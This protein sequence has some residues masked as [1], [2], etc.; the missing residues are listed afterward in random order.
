MFFV[1][2]KE[3]A[4]EKLGG[5]KAV[6]DEYKK[7]DN[8]ILK[9][10]KYLKMLAVESVKS[11]L[12]Q[13]TM[14]NIGEGNHHLQ[15]DSNNAVTVVKYFPREAGLFLGAT[16][17]NAGINTDFFNPF[18]SICYL[19]FAVLFVVL[20]VRKT[21]LKQ[22]DSIYLLSIMIVFGICFNNIMNASLAN[23][24]N[25]FGVRVIWLMAFAALLMLVE[26]LVLGREK[27][28]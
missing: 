13:F 25:R 19:L 2:E 22:F 15:K 23:A 5:W 17:N 18:Y 10:P 16:Q 8:A 4:T 6:K 27:K 24:I 1:W 12:R 3:G 28:V 7:I 14:N 11:S 20:F 9:D 26:V 21:V